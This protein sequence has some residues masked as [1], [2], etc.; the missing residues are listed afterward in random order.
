MTWR[1]G[2]TPRRCPM[3]EVETEPD[4]WETLLG[5]L[6]PD[7]RAQLL[8]SVEDAR[9]LLEDRVVWSVNATGQGGGVAEM[10]GPML[11][12]ARA[13]GVDA[14]WLVLGGAADFF[15]VT[16]RPHN[17]LHGCGSDEG[18]LG[19]AER[20]L[21]ESVLDENLSACLEHISPG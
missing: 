1:C 14:R 17:M 16:K 11:G 2:R 21:Y 13:A 12:Y 4:R 3:H 5:L 20:D 15:A 19:A 9:N 6:S 10:C 7:R 18:G 8:Q